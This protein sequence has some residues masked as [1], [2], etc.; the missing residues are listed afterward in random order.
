MTHGDFSNTMENNHPRRSGQGI[1]FILATVC[2]FALWIW[3]ASRIFYGAD[4]QDEALY[5]SLPLS[6]IRGREI[7]AGELG[8][9]QTASWIL[10][11]FSWLI[12]IFKKDS[13][14]SIVIIFRIFYYTLTLAF[15]FITRWQLKKLDIATN[16]ATATAFLIASFTPFGI[17]G[18]SYNTLG[19]MFFCM[20]FLSFFHDASHKKTP[21]TLTSIL[22]VLAAFSHLSMIPCVLLLV[23]WGLYS[24]R[25]FP[26]RFFIIS[27]VSAAIFFAVVLGHG[28]IERLKDILNYHSSF[29]LYGPSHSSKL[30]IWK[31]QILANWK[32]FSLSFL[33]G[34]S[35][36]L[37]SIPALWWIWKLQTDGW[38]VAPT[39]IIILALAFCA[40]LKRG[41][42]ARI[43]FFSG[44]WT[45]FMSSNG[46]WNFFCGGLGGVA[47]L[48]SRLR[49]PVILCLH[50]TIVAYQNLGVYGDDAPNFLTAQIESG[51]YKGLYTSPQRKDLFA[52]LNTDLRSLNL[53]TNNSIAF[54]DLF[55][56]GYLFGNW[57][58]GA[59]SVMTYPPDHFPH[60]RSYLVKYI[61]ETS[62]PDYIVQFYKLQFSTTSTM[63]IKI[64]ES[65]PYFAKIKLLGYRSLIKND[66]YEILGKKR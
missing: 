25:K 38:S 3:G 50:L 12:S 2:S 41:N 36:F 44:L 57:K 66:V 48:C 33:S 54:H 24:S 49:T 17:P 65:D 56:G 27:G 4:F 5:I 46:L 29:A 34:I 40:F 9:V 52:R 59:A 45:A 60:D 6:F 51:P 19:M 28:G 20:G 55:P 18:L 15:A 47:L 10:I 23:T 21:G 11:P 8:L 16:R 61:N 39:H 31:T 63:E 37:V 1:C 64:P 30:Q 22:L 14:E 32:F 35:N 7:W 53:T 43:S 58:V 62:P 13:V 26:T 42:L